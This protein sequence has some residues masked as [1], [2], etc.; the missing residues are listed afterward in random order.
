MTC[1][2]EILEPTLET[3]RKALGTCI[4]HNKL[5][6]DYFRFP[7]G[8]GAL[9]RPAALPQRQNFSTGQHEGPGPPLLVAAIKETVAEDSVRSLAHCLWGETEPDSSNH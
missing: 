8:T 7:K 3:S 1:T 5:S 2:S 4:E 9:E 6:L